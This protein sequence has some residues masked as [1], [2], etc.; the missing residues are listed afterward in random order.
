MINLILE[1]SKKDE[2]IGRLLERVK[3]YAEVY[4]LA[5]NRQKGCNGMGEVA[6]LRDEFNSVLEEL[7][8]YCRE[9]GYIG[10]VI[11]DIDQFAHDILKMG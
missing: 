11:I 3:E 8:R 1:V 4:I 10:D 7:I 6:T 5:K 2:E 9:R